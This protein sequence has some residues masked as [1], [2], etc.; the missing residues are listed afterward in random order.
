MNISGF[1]LLKPKRTKGRGPAVF[2]GPLENMRGPY[3]VG[4]AFGIGC[5]GSVEQPPFPAQE[6]FPLQPWSLVLHPPLPEQEFLPAHSCFSL[7]AFLVAFFP[8]SWVLS[9]GAS[10]VVALAPATNPVRAAPIS[11]ALS[12]FVMVNLLEVS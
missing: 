8:E 6:F 5:F 11:S 9:L 3:F 2:A 4:E 10:C 1:R 12:D 7:A